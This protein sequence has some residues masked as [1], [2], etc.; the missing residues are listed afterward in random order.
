[1]V[2]LT[3]GHCALPSLHPQKLCPVFTKEVD[4][5]QPVC[6]RCQTEIITCAACGEVMLEPGVLML[7]KNKS[8]IT[9]CEHC[10]KK[11]KY[12]TTCVHY[13]PCDFETNPVAIP[14][15]VMKEIR[16]GNMI[17]QQQIRNP[18]RIRQTCQKNCKCYREDLECLK[19]FNTCERW[20]S[21]L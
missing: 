15:Y 4:V 2:N 19:Q 1:M 14:K 8:W 9:V 13:Q 5:K 11:M 3:C 20:E 7:N 10:S 16:Q 6:P 18:E 17:A 21:I 12:C